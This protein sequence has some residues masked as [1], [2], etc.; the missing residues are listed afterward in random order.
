MMNAK[1]IKM[2]NNLLASKNVSMTVNGKQEVRLY[3]LRDR[4]THFS[5]YYSKVN[6]IEQAVRGD[7]SVGKEAYIRG[8][9]NTIK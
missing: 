9:W 4:G 6:G 1:G 3:E 8:K 7:V 2:I 5:I